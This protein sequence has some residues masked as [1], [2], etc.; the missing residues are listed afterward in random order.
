MRFNGTSH[1]LQ[2]GGGLN[3]INSLPISFFAVAN[4]NATQT[5]PMGLFDSAPGAANPF[6]FFNDGSGAG[7][8]PPAGNGNSVE[9]WSNNP[10][11]GGYALNASAPTIVSAIG[12]L[13]GGNRRLTVFRDAT[14]IGTATGNATGVNFNNPQFGRINNGNW[15]SGDLG[16]AILF[17]GV[18]L[19][20]AQRL[21]VE[22]HLGAKFGRSLGVNDF[23]V[24]AVTG[25][26]F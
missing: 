4:S 26:Y 22:N 1:F 9:F 2:M 19:N 6:R 24:N 5:N 11:I 8:I 10:A 15:F 14:Q 20:A 25:S 17:N 12:D 21:V 3:S 16:D 7:N 23:Y 13:S 18:A